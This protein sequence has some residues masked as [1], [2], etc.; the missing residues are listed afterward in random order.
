MIMD[1]ATSSQDPM[2]GEHKTF[3]SLWD[4]LL[5][6]ACSRLT[7]TAFH[8]CQQPPNQ[9]SYLLSECENDRKDN[10]LKWT[11]SQLLQ[12]A[13]TLGACLQNAGMKPRS[14]F[15]VFCPNTVEWVVLFWACASIG[16]VFAPLNSRLI[17]R[18]TE[19]RHVLECLQP[20]AVAVFEPRCIPVLEKECGHIINV[21]NSGIKLS[22]SSAVDSVVEGWQRLKDLPVP[23]N[24]VYHPETTL[25]DPIVILLTS[26]TPSLPKLCPLT[27][28]NIISQTEAFWN[29]RRLRSSSKLV[30]FGP[31]FHIQTIW[32]T[33]MAWRAGAAV[34]F[35][36]AT[37]DASAIVDAM[38]NL[39]C[40]HLSCT[41]SVMFSLIS[42][43]QF[44]RNGYTDLQ[45]LALGAERVTKDLIERCY[46]AF[47]PEKVIN[48]WGMTEGI[49][50]LG[51]DLEEPAAWRD[52]TLS[53][54]HVMPNHNIRICHPESMQAVGNDT[55]GELHV[56]GPTV[57]AGYYSKGELYRTDSF[58]DEDDR[59]WFKTGD[60]VVMDQQG[61]VYF[62]GRYKDL[63]IRG[64][65]NINPS[66]IE[67]CLNR[68]PGVE[69]SSD[70]KD[71]RLTADANTSQSQV[72]GIDDQFTGQSICAVL[73]VENQHDNDFDIKI[74]AQSRVLA[75]LGPSSRMASI[76]L[77][78]DLDMQI[79]PR[80]ATGKMRKVDLVK[81]VQ[82]KKA[83]Q[84]KEKV[85]RSTQDVL[86]QLWQRVLGA[87]ACEIHADT[88]VSQIADSLVIL[89]FSFH[90]EQEFGT[91]ISAADVLEHETPRQQASILN[92]R[93]G[94]RMSS[95]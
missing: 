82:E 81:A 27:S 50:I 49:S 24:K 75:E 62:E 29:M 34:V 67:T 32:N 85:G 72:V 78:S 51:A 16:I 41:P 91:R 37:Y 40:T 26:G 18:P 74:E 44:S 12:A 76:F 42:Q 13:R 69:V 70:M 52:G 31:G 6:S 36:S 28:R 15:A 60:S 14:T 8:S 79:F 1:P 17:E 47:K 9:L 10:H 66:V 33:I 43:P 7:Q 22:M 65:E 86:I 53:L 25:D 3:D 92:H 5:S 88:V 84:P 4:L 57:I 95:E 58:H 93:S 64:G 39:P 83:N 21:G 48:G 71:K 87:E 2:I 77:L 55:V 35:P 73:R 54:G 59:T 45:S 46:S 56:S 23:G 61:H 94:P 38:N 20:D 63:I 80:T 90:V 30:A 19:L 11:Y 68:I 89:R